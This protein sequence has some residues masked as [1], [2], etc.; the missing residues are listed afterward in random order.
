MNCDFVAPYYQALEYVSFG[1]SLERRR[2]AFLS[3]AT[4]SRNAL[5]CGGGDGRFLARLL[6]ANS[7]VRVDFVD[8]S[9]KMVDLAERRITAMGRA[10][11]ARVRFHVADLRTFEPSP[12]TYDLV[13]T[14][15]FLDC[16]SDSEVADLAVTLASWTVPQAQ[17]IVS[18]F[19]QAQGRFAELW[20]NLVVRALYA[21]F[22][23]STNLQVTRLPRYEDAL[24][25]AGFH[26]QRREQALGGLLRSSL[27]QR[28]PVVGHPAPQY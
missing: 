21:A 20:T 13:V 17:W 4:N 5:L 12:G 26:L 7:G 11:R 23:V 22:R 16:F 24:S 15:F 14:H 3:A 1:K 8:L 9:P 6:R 2:W 25:S 27:W 19:E 10:F 18:E 28:L